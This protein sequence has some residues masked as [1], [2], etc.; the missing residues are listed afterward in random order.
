MKTVYVAMSADLIHTGHLNI[1]EEARKYGD[2]VIGLLTDKAI[3]SY[4]R[5][6]YMAFEQRKKIIESIK[7]VGEVIPQE[8]LDYVP[9]LRKI[10]PDFVVHGDD[11]KTGI[12]RETRQRVIDAL[13]EWGGTLIEP[14]YT[15]GISSSQLNAVQKEIG[16]T[17]G[18]RLNMLRRLLDSKD[19]IRI[20]E[21]HSGLCGLIAESVSVEREGRKVEFDG[22]WLSSLTDSTS[23]GKPD[24]GYVDLTSRRNTLNDILEVTTK[25]IIY[26]GDSGGLTEHFVFMVRA[27]ER[28]GISAVIIEDKVG[29]KKNSLFGTDVKQT[30]DSIENFSKKIRAGKQAQITSDFMV[31]ARVESLILKTGMEDAL[32][33]AKAYIAAGADAI[34][35]HSKEKTP[36]EILE[37][38]KKF[39]EFD[40]K[41][42]LVVVPSTYNTITE[43][44]LLKAGVRIVIYANQLLRSAYPA[45]L[46]TAETILHSGRAQEV[47]EFCMP[48]KEILHL[49]PGGD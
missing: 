22:M 12:Q 20:I 38:C 17:P 9:N 37:F 39:A 44:E 2:L 40:I 23:K 45:M 35:I 29:L 33:R 4:K 8:T 16:T 10:K 18:V 47:E 11:W 31:V 1:I 7:G 30:Q 32:K 46:K 43:E 15:Q 14:H 41:V 26:D 6:P 5:L 42:P 48:I 36:D 21:A 25:P 28:D 19:I 13:H 24:I 3:A 27:L 49:I 34:M